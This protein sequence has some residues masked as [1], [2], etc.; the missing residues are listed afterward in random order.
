[1]D[2][3]RSA[4]ALNNAGFADARFDQIM[5]EAA[6]LEGTARMNRLAEAERIVLSAQVVL[7]L[8]GY[9]SKHLVSDRIDGWKD[10]LLDR[11]PSAQLTWREK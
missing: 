7:P 4:Q 3:F 1:M 2:L 6:Q 8:Y 5:D 10:H 9:V 11:H